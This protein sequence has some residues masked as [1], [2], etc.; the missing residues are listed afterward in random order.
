MTRRQLTLEE[1]EEITVGTTCG[2]TVRPMLPDWAGQ[3]RVISRE[4]RRNTSTRGYLAVTAD[5]RARVG[6]RR[7]QPRMIDTD[8]MVR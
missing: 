5:R 4:I 3:H 8:V 7:V 1:R 6:P 2:E